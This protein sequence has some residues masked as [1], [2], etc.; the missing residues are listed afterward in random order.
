MN[1]KLF[2]T[3]LLISLLA[4]SASA[5][6][7]F[8]TTPDR[9]I[10]TASG[11]ISADLVDVSPE[12][13][14]KVLEIMVSEGQYVETGE[15]LFRMDD[16]ILVAQKQQAQA[17][18]NLALASV[19]AAEEQ[20]KA[21]ELQVQRA[22]QG[23]R[24]LAL[25]NGQVL[26]AT[27]AEDTPTDFQQ[28]YWYYQKSEGLNAAQYEVDEARSR[29][30]TE[31]ANL[32]EVQSKASSENFLSLEQNLAN[33]RARF[34][35][36]ELTLQQSKQARESGILQD[37]AQKEYDSALA[38]LE[39]Y[40]R[41]YDQELTS[42]AAEEVLEARAKL[43]V[44]TARLENAQTQL[45]LLQYGEDSLDVQSARAAV[46]SA[47]A[48]LEQ[49][50]A[51]VEQAQAALAL[52]D[53]QLSKSSVNAASAG[54][55]LVNNLQEGELA[56]A[57]SIAMTIGKLEEVS[58]VV[59]VPED[60][61]GRVQLN[62]KVDIS[63]DSYPGKTYNGEVIYIAQQAEFTPRN[64]QTVEG[65]KATVYAIKIRIPNPNNELKPGMPADVDFG[66]LLND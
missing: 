32:E 51:G 48:Q 56:G 10:I 28:P 3:F 39:T 15:L 65:R 41:K 63:V 19:K 62:Q 30:E 29:V 55:I 59:Y 23:A 21:A 61:Y 37:M 54:T 53:I 13:S 42:A 8:D 20:L 34:L 64:V 44:A 26:A 22:E 16:E 58:L 47:A 36:A 25:Q 14:G 33:T 49:A 66:I 31:R 5:C 27:W 24:L 4:V 40:Q 38:D 46:N 12:I 17:G 18:L 1:R 57:G 9:T 45:D 6:S 52:L 50:Q 35:V 60:A 11:T 43:A 7:V 2:I